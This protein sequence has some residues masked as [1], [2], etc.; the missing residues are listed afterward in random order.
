M[1][2][3]DNKELVVKKVMMKRMKKELD[4]LYFQVNH[5][6]L[7]NRKIRF[8]RRLKLALCTGKLIAPY[9]L[10]V[11]LVFGLFS[12]AGYTPF[13]KDTNKK[14]LQIKTEM[15][16]LGNVNITG[17]Y[18]RF[19]DKFASITYYGKWVKESDNMFVRNVKIYKVGK[20]NEEDIVRALENPNSLK[21]DDIFGKPE[22][23]AIEKR[24]NL[25]RDE[26]EKEPYLLAIVYSVDGNDVAYVEETNSDNATTTLLWFLITIIAQYI[27][28]TFTNF[29]YEKE[30]NDIK[31][32]YH[33]TT[34]KNLEKRLKIKQA[35]Y[36]R[37][38]K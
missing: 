9:A 8:L 36:D 27:P 23:D 21:L 16:S 34:T 17:Q 7:V 18:G 25:S 30:K 6:D 20:D 28:L 12:L 14:K 32:T 37:L 31:N 3:L 19:K 35:N 11:S 22:T 26:V 4:E 1:D 10:T 2:C 13:L 38:V 29:D 33:E 5:V 15:D 24:N